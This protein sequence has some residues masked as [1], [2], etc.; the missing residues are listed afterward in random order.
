M[1]EM[2]KVQ[3]LKKRYGSF[4]AV[5]DINFAVSKG[6]VV[7]FLGPNGAG[8]STTM[9]ILCG[10]IG[11][12]SGEVFIDAYNMHTHPIQS[13]RIIGYLPENPPLYPNMIV[14]EYLQF[15]GTIK[16]VTDIS[17]AITRNY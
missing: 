11:A 10:C 14:E 1:W 12:S 17:K 4:E 13:K 16:G 2:I 8:K 15:C 7:G 5:T 3:H 9:R 6:E